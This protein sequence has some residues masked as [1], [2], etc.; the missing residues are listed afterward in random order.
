MYNF[1]IIPIR[2][3]YLQ[4]TSISWDFAFDY[5]GDL[6]F[7]VDI[8]LRCFF[9]SYFDQDGLVIE[10]SRILCHYIFSMQFKLHFLAAIP[11][12]IFIWMG[13]LGTLGKTQTLSIFRLLKLLRLLDVY[14]LMNSA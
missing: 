10:R 6:V 7:L 9:M 13:S 5:L 4:G 8:V 14:N 11:L 2:I 1:I 12:D 3:A